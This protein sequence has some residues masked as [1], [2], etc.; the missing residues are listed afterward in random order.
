[1][2][3]AADVK[4][5]FVDLDKIDRGEAYAPKKFAKD[6]ASALDN[7]ATKEGQ[8]A[9]RDAARRFLFTNYGI[10]TR[11]DRNEAPTH[12][13]AELP[14]PAWASEDSNRYLVKTRA[15]MGGNLGYHTF[16]G[17]IAVADDQ[18]KM[19]TNAVVG[20]RD[21]KSYVKQLLKLGADTASALVDPLSTILHEETHGAS[22][23]R[24]TSY[25]GVGV[26]MEEALT[27][28]I[29][30]RAT[31]DFLGVKFDPRR[32]GSAPL[33]P[34]VRITSAEKTY[35]GGN[36]SYNGYI[37]GLFNIVAEHTG[38]DDI[39]ERIEEAAIK[40]RQWGKGEAYTKPEEQAADFV[41]YLRSGIDDHKGE[42]PDEVRQ[43][44]IAALTDPAGPM[45]K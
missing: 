14:K 38:H 31:R 40:V 43:R 17:L 27:E 21:N 22:K 5:T 7:F 42:I 23:G 4:V 10:A 13:R 45:M 12:T 41:R 15:E 8:K 30:R 39:H 1:M 9:V 33:E 32:P 2:G 26:G 25:Q 36:G 24:S 11:D 18:H 3:Y 44:L 37:R 20:M 34:P 28:L 29:A 19:T 16:K 6:L 35:K